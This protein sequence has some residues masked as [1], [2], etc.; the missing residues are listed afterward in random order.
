ME[1]EVIRVT[2]PFRS[3][4]PADCVV[5]RPVRDPSLRL[6]HYGPVQPMDAPTPYLALIWR[7]VP[8][9]V[10]LF[11]FFAIGAALVAVLS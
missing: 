6:K 11:L 4:R 10:G 1:S 2:P 9:G 8:G 7:A 5:P 3:S